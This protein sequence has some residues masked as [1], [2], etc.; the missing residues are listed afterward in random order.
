MQPVIS[1]LVMTVALAALVREVLARRAPGRFPL[2]DL[3]RDRFGTACPAAAWL[4]LGLVAGACDALGPTAA[5]WTAGWVDVGATGWPATGAL[6]RVAA[7]VPLAL[8][9][10]AGEELVFRGAI[11]PQARRLMPAWAAVALSAC[12]FSLAHASRADGSGVMDLLVYLADGCGFAAVFLGT[13]SLWLPTLWHA[14][15]N[16]LVWFVF[17]AGRFAIPPGL[18]T[19]VPTGH[20]AWTGTATSAG[21]LDVLVAAAVATGAGWLATRRKARPRV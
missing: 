20:E 21:W 1:A 16:L 14:S 2:A 13:G 12:L 18:L 7:A 19:A 6:V 8:A 17:G 11:L 15:K 3:L 9:W 5:G 10:A 4:G